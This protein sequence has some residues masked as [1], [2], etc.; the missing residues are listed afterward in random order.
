MTTPMIN[1]RRAD[2]ARRRQRVLTTLDNA[3][4][5]GSEISIS[6]IARAAGVH[7]TFFYRHP[8]LIEL[9]H[10][11]ETNPRGGT[12]TTATVSK[13]S[14][15]ADLANAKGRAARQD[16]RIHQLERKLTEL[17]GE[18]AWAESGLDAH[19]DVEQLKR[20]I[21]T[22]EEH[23]AD[24]T[25]E[26]DERTQDLEAARASNRELMTRLNTPVKSR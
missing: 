7:R 24:R 2:T 15:L 5:T 12:N 20:R 11:A 25:A 14:L 18:Q 21:T 3:I 26:L 23:L 22:L 1:G 13:A 17:L 8:D 9:V 16:A 6:A 10:T 19:D 4:V